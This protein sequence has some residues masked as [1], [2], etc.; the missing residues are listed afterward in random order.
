MCM[1]A[2]FT[3]K[4]FGRKNRARL[5]YWDTLF[6]DTMRNGD[7]L[8]FVSREDEDTRYA[9]ELLTRVKSRVKFRIVKAFLFLLFDKIKFSY[10]YMCLYARRHANCVDKKNGEEEMT[11]GERDCDDENGNAIRLCNFSNLNLILDARHVIETRQAS[12]IRLARFCRE[13]VTIYDG[14]THWTFTKL[15]LLLADRRAREYVARAI[16]VAARRNAV[17]ARACFK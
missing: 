8:L 3:F 16:Y 7:E 12:R 10:Q 13:C 4:F 2:Y 15:F 14:E 17:D 6:W 5:L 11:R 1:V 9:L